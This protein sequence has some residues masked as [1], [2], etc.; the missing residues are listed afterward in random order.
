[1]DGQTAM[2]PHDHLS[3]IQPEGLL[4]MFSSIYPNHSVRG[5]LGSSTKE[6]K[7]EHTDALHTEYSAYKEAF[8]RSASLEA[9]NDRG[10]LRD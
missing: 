5:K 8:D 6:L 2:L 1:M 7:T 10:G 4:Q 3:C 9:G